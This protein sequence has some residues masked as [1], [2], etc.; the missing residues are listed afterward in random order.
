MRKT[1]LILGV[2]L[3]V[4]GAAWAANTVTVTAGAALQGNFGMSVNFDG[5]TNNAYV[6][7]QSPNDESVYHVTFTAHRNTWDPANTASFYVL[8]ARNG[9]PAINNSIRFYVRENP[10]APGT[11][12]AR[13][14]ARWDNLTWRQVGCGNFGAVEQTYEIIW[15]RSS[16]VDTNDGE[17]TCLRNGVAPPANTFTALDNDEMAVD[18][19]RFGFFQSAPLNQTATGSFYLDDFI[20]TRT[21]P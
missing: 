1:I 3:L 10:A 9:E 19:I 21:A 12:H 13:A 20:S 6:E 2:A 7:D 17:I 11:Y 4:S 15:K 8:T 5:S 14:I 16:G 18:S